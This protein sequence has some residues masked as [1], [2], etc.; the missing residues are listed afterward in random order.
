MNE[1]TYLMEIGVRVK[2]WVAYKWMMGRTLFLSK[3]TQVP[4]LNRLTDLEMLYQNI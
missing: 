2:G 1:W 3:A 4:S